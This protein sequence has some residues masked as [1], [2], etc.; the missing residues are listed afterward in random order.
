MLIAPRDRGGRWRPLSWPPTPLTPHL[1]G[2]P[3]DRFAPPATI[4]VLPGSHNEIW[5]TDQDSGPIARRTVAEHG[6]GLAVSWEDSGARTGPHEIGLIANI[7]AKNDG[8]AAR[9]LYRKY[10]MELFRFGFHVLHDQGLAEDMVQ[11]TFI[12]FCQQAPNYRVDRGPVRGWLFTMARSTAYDVARRPSSR[13]FLP[14]EDFQL[15]PQY[16]TVDQALTVLTVDQ[17]LDKLPSIYSDVMRL[18]RD[19]FTQSEIAERLGIPIGTVKSRMAKA[20]DTLR[21]ELASLRSGGDD[22]V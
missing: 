9:R 5:E 10:R 14:V 20:A 21:A 8:D 6:W 7:A 2:G 16:D 3:A 12:K 13:P 11:E 19:G 15:P 1:R 22:A 18:V 17:A 4:S